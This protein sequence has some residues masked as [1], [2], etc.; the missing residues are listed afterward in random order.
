MS[1]KSNLRAYCLF[2]SRSLIVSGL[3]FKH[4]IHFEFI[5]V[6]VVKKWWGFI[7]LHI[8]VQFYQHHWEKAL[9]IL[10]PLSWPPLLYIIC[11]YKHG[12]IFLDSILLIDLFLWKYHTLL[13]WKLYEKLHWYFDCN[14]IEYIVLDNIDILIKL[15]FSTHEQCIFPLICIVF[16]FLF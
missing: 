2:S 13:I 7:P 15:I 8:V 12:F 6:Y 16:N 9:Y 1:G 10:F 4:L 14:C 3:I 5:F 11:T